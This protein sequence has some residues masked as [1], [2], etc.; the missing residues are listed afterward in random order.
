MLED[1]FTQ[2][3]AQATVEMSKAAIKACA[4]FVRAKRP[5]IEPGLDAAK[6]AGDGD[7]FERVFR[8]AVGVIDAAAGSGVINIDKVTLTALRGIRFDH[9]HG[10]VGITGRVVSGGVLATGGSQG[11]TGR[12][13]VG[14]N[15]SLRS[16]GTAIEVGHGCSIVMTGGASIKQS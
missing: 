10:L 5:D 12:T 14:G 15:T 2:V 6:A 7:Q 4:D 16:R 9:Q 13:V 8:E 1:Y 11:S 3:A